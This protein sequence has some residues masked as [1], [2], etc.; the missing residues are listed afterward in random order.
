L[1]VLKVATNAVSELK[2]FN[3][4]SAKFED[5]PTVREFAAVEEIIKKGFLS[6]NVSLVLFMMYVRS[7]EHLPHSSMG[8]GPRGSR[9]YQL[10]AI[11]TSNVW[12]I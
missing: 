12:R 3:S 1:N 8:I 10:R 9:I 7:V 4:E 6:F 11:R 2:N 5:H